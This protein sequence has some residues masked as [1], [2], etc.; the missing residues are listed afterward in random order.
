VKHWRFAFYIVLYLAQF[1]GIAVVTHL[2][3]PHWPPDQVLM[4]SLIIFVASWR[5]SHAVKQD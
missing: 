2:V 3:A 4:W 1:L 5:A